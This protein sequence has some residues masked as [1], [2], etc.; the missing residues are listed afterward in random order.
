MQDSKALLLASIVSLAAASVGLARESVAIPV[1]EKASPPA[2]ESQQNDLYKDA[3]RL[4]NEGKWDLAAARFAAV[5]KVHDSLSPGA[6]YWQAYSLQRLG[7]RSEASAVASQVGKAY[8]HSRWVRE[9]EALLIEMGAASAPEDDSDEDL[10]LLALNH[11]MAHDEEQGL[12]AL[13]KFLDSGHSVKLMKNALFVLAQ[14]RSPAAKQLLEQIASGARYP[15]LQLQAIFD[16]GLEG[17]VDNVQTLSRLYSDSADK[18]VKRKILETYGVARQSTPLLAL[19]R[20]EN[21]SELRALPIHSLGVGGAR[22]E[23]EGLYKEAAS[24]ELKV[25]L[26]HSMMVAGSESTLPRIAPTQPP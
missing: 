25:E 16:L 12:Q 2:T 10:K 1:A 7:R 11:L 26:L 21:D 13:R 24:A 19:I 3:T 23:L 18:Q 15:Q 17:G 5:A 4:M 9:S 14:S 6:L 8:P 22:Q 20:Q